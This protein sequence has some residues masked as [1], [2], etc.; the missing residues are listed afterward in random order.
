MFLNSTVELIF[1]YSKR[2]SCLYSTMHAL[3]CVF[4]LSVQSL[5]NLLSF[6]FAWASFLEESETE[7]GPVV[8][9]IKVEKLSIAA[10]L[11]VLCANYLT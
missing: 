10:R 8:N 9:E 2:V 4:R 3:F 11:Q 6:M 7:R 1:L 5:C